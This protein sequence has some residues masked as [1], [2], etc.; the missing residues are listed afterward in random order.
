MKA[1]Q[2][3]RT[4]EY[5]AL[6]RA[7]ETARAPQCRIVED[8]LAEHLLSQPL[9]S[10]AGL[11]HS[12]GLAAAVSRYID[13]RQPGA[14]PSVI[15]RTRLIDDYLITAL[16]DG[17]TQIVILGAGFDTRPYRMDGIE[18]ACVFEVDHPNTSAVKRERVRHALGALPAQVSY[19][20]FD[21]DRGSLSDAL[22][23][24]GFDAACRTFFI[25]EGVTSYLTEEAVNATLKFV[26]GAPEGSRVVLTYV[27]RDVV[28]SPERFLGGN[29][30]HRRLKRL[31]ERLTFGFDPADVPRFLAAR[32]LRLIDD[33]GSVEYRARFLG[34][35]GDHLRGH[36]FYR[37]AIAQVGRAD[38]GRSCQ[39]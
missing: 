20:A 8:Q 13:Y 16:K 1:K 11:A 7:L 28:C 2:A 3:S 21:F 12:A 9:R 22:A 37:V 14:R 25:W 30:L 33:I 23:R 36:E 4:A 5:N 27:H 15:A 39:A 18:K 32:G 17:I 29:R 31:E 24:A 35:S 6:F 19:V 26:G 38:A 34:A 10:V